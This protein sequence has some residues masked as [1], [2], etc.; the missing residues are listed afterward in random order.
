MNE[1]QQLAQMSQK[2]ADLLG[3]HYD[4]SQW[5]SMLR[6]VKIAAS[7]LNRPNS[8]NHLLEW[9]SQSTF[10]KNEMDALTKNLTIGETYFFREQAGL[11]LLIKKIIPDLIAQKGSGLRFIRIW[12]AGCSTGEE[13]YSIA[14]LLKEH[15]PDIEDWD[16]SI[17]ATDINQAALEKARAGIYT[18][19]SFRETP[20]EIKAKYFTEYGKTYRISEEVKSMVRFSSI[21]LATDKFP[22][23]LNYTE[24]M[25]V[26]FCRNVLMYFKP[27]IIHKVARQLF[28]A[29]VDTGWLITS[30]VELSDEYFGLFSRRMFENGIF[31]QKCQGKEGVNRTPSI[32]KNESIKKSTARILPSQSRTMKSKVE[33]SNKAGNF[34][35][36][37]PNS[38][39]INLSK[40]Q[41][42]LNLS[43]EADALY[44]ASRY[45]ECV[46]AC[47]KVLESN[48]FDS[49]IALLLAKSYANMGKLDDAM[50]WIER[51]MGIDTTNADAR[52][53]YATIL[54][55]RKEWEK[56]EK[57]LIE[58][59]YLKPDMLA[60]QLH[61]G[62]VYMQLGKKNLAHKL[63]D[64]LIKRLEMWDDDEIVPD[65]DGMTARR[66]ALMTQMLKR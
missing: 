1:S 22:S 37:K 33:S 44:I 26:V 48:E 24:Q 47:N 23:Q 6:C 57:A 13:P 4:E 40:Q 29:L 34:S 56:A 52:N 8:L 65:L 61:L 25:N 38:Q 49:K 21:N 17:L 55:E 41:N 9:V 32:V 62:N 53:V 51:V 35:R 54:I 27:K 19:W 15:I 63:F 30:Q 39:H 20:E 3:L 11:A 45:P 5:M 46:D 58:T 10:E 12:S 66:L 36:Q 18:A 59:L 16:I 50:H 2:L 42:V 43:I 14:I 7:E 28:D 60:A 64:Q 31:Y